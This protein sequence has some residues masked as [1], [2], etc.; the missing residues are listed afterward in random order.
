MTPKSRGSEKKDMSGPDQQKTGHAGWQDDRVDVLVLP[1][2]QILC[3][4]SLPLLHV[5]LL[6]RHTAT[7]ES[8][9]RPRG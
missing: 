7:A 2:W 4:P 8:E 6:C 5:P 1:T 9:Q 3:W